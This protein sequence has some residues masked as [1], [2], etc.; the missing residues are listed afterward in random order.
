ME[1]V[2]KTPEPKKA[3]FNIVPILT[4][5]AIGYIGFLLYQAVYFNYQTSQQIRSLKND[6]KQIDQEKAQIESLIAYYKTSTFQELEARK[7]LGMKAPGEKVVQ[8]NVEE[9]ATNQTA[10]EGETKIQN[11]KSNPQA[12][13]DFLLGQEI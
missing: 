6:L 3:R 2:Q 8:V 9:T 10:P 7:K 4:L 12:W 5:L 1:D 11:K 13:L